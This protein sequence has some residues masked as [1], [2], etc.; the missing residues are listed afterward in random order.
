M[1]TNSRNRHWNNSESSSEPGATLRFRVLAPG[2]LAILAPMLPWPSALLIWRSSP[3]RRIAC[4]AV[5]QSVKS[6]ARRSHLNTYSVHK[7]LSHPLGISGAVE[8]RIWR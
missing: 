1:T 8:P 2:R 3:Q 6:L 7:P 4:L 5:V